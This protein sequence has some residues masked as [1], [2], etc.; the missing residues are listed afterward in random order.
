MAVRGT[1]VAV[2]D[3]TGAFELDDVPAHDSLAIRASHPTRGAVADR[4]VAAGETELELALVPYGGI[5]GVIAGEASRVTYVWIYPGG[6]DAEILGDAFHFDNLRP[7]T[8]RLT[9]YPLPLELGGIVVAAGQRTRVTLTLPPEGIAVTLHAPGGC[10]EI[11]LAATRYSD[12]CFAG[13][14]TLPYVEPGTYRACIDRI[15]PCLPITVA[16]SPPQQT[17]ELP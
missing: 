2:T 12:A 3:E 1:W 13:E 17:I 6:G 5:D 11:W 10:R 8:Y 16:P 9:G 15:E 7:G 4:E 14:A